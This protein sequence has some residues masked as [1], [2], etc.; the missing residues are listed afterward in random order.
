M[1][2]TSTS[3]HSNIPA[4]ATR[5]VGIG[6]SAGGLAALESFLAA[7]PPDSG[8]AYVVVQHLD[9]TQKT[10]LAELLQRITPMPVREAEQGMPIEPDAVFV[11]PPDTELRVV[12]ERL[13]LS[14]PGE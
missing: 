11:I 10:L 3:K 7:V 1:T 9:P 8:M 6:A 13:D 4:L 14:H 5:I 2:S 12:D